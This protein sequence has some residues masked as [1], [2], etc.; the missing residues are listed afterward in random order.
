MA[1]SSAGF[2]TNLDV[3]AIVSQLMAVERR[4]LT[5][6]AQQDAR[7]QAQI[8]AWGSTK[9]VLAG[10]QSA[11]KPLAGVGTFLGMK[12]A[13]GDTAVAVAAASASATAGAYALEV[14]ALAQQ[15]K[16][17]TD[18]FAQLS[19]VIGEGTLT[20]QFGTYVSAGNSFTL[21]S[22]KAA[23]TV[24]IGAAQNTL[25]GI[26]DA[27]NAAG[28]GVTASI[29]NDGGANHLVFTGRDSGAACSMRVTV[30]DADGS[31]TNASG[32]SRLAFDPT[33]AAGSGKN[34]TQVAAAQD[35]ALKIDGIA[36]VRDSNVVKDAIGGVTLTLLKTNAGTPTTLNVTRDTQAAKSAIQN[37]VK[38]Y[39]SAAKT[40]GDLIGYNPATKSAGMLQG[41]AVANN[42]ATHLRAQISASVSALQ[43]SVNS[44]PLMGIT[45]Q[46]DGSLAIDDA[47]LQAAL[48]DNLAEVSRVFAATGTP[49]HALVAHKG[50]TSATAEGTYAVTVT[51]L[52]TRG[53]LAGSAAA[54]LTITAGVNDSVAVTI[55]GVQATVTL[56]AGIYATAGALAAELQ[57]RIN[58]ATV[59][60]AAGASVTV[61]ES[62]GVFS[63]SSDLYGSSSTAS[64][65]TGAAADNL[66]GAGRTA[67]AGVDVA[68]TINGAIATG[69]G[70]TLTGAAGNAAEGLSLDMH[71]VVATG[72]YGTVGFTKGLAHN[73]D[74]LI[75]GLLETSGTVA[76]RTGMLAARSKDVGRRAEAINNRL[77]DTE[78]RYRAQFVA[79]DGMLSRMNTTS[80]FLTSQLA[81]LPG[82]VK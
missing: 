67:T 45:F 76:S 3:N 54:G 47:K 33:A 22:A 49:S 35:A 41:D 70:N 63:L 34:L 29:I 23:Q 16:L 42:M 58:G 40:I 80:N 50:Y 12:A 18:G 1:V 20:F 31:H 7:I 21:N 82:A 56:A 44:L 2:G 8:S 52:A 5:L 79:L 75:T 59:L 60:A 77:A 55:N 10:L 71:A 53:A 78:K 48:D 51:Q 17:R 24:T 57:T 37:A 11:L 46:K 74:I 36:V 6:L 15:H 68:G 27:V 4:P 39:N 13:T 26:R 66:F 30:G 72:S 43:G 73:A 32:L 28:I 38:A 81:N 14:T 19:D 62:A 64:L 61:T 69:A 65:A 9:G 25:A